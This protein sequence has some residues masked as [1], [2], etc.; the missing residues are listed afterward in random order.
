MI[1]RID[2]PARFQALNAEWDELLKA[3]SADSPFLTW[4][5]LWSWW[6][7][8]AAD[9]TLHILAFRDRDRLVAIA[10]LMSRTLRVAGLAP[11]RVLEF[12]GTGSVGSD[13]LDLIV[14]RGQEA[15]ALGAF[16]D[17]LAKGDVALE[18]AQL[19]AN[20]AVARLEARI[21]AARGRHRP[22][23]VAG[24]ALRGQGQRR[25]HVGVRV[26]EPA[27]ACGAFGADEAQLVVGAARVA[28]GEQDRALP[29]RV[30]VLDEGGDVDGH[31]AAVDGV[32]LVVSAAH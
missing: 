25:H 19:D 5:W 30:G 12:L 6:K 16:A 22:R 31:H 17:Y 8:L 14:R 18:M 29:G 21:R 20:A 23:A 13:Y 15:E 1:D 10:P 2:D 27:G 11:V 28:D 9:G 7:H 24:D 32:V 4:E 3:S 26:G